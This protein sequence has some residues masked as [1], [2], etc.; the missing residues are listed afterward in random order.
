MA[1]NGHITV[2]VVN[3]N[4]V[5]VA[6][7]VVA[8]EGYNT[9]VGGDNRLTVVVAACD[10]NAVVHSA[11]APFHKACDVVGVGKRPNKASGCAAC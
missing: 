2:A 9:A 3:H 7:A 1:V 5:A 8:C 11:P 4:V 10:V 6:A